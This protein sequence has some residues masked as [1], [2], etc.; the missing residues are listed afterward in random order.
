MREAAHV[1]CLCAVITLSG[2]VRGRLGQRQ[3]DHGATAAEYALVAGLIAVVIVA[4]VTVFG[5]KVSGLF[6]VPAGVF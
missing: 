6:L 3:G 4:A 1:V 5:R 2:L